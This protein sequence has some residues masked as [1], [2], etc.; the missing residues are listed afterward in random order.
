VA[1]GE[2]MKR[3]EARGSDHGPESK[4]P[5]VPYKIHVEDRAFELPCN[6]Q[7]TKQYCQHPNSTTS[8]EDIMTATAKPPSHYTNDIK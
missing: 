5:L 4:N 2:V 8:A 1:V 3:L 6:Y 7:T